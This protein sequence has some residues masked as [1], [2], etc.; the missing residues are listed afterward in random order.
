MQHSLS[1]HLCSGNEIQ[2][3][4]DTAK[5]MELEWKM[6]WKWK[7]QN[8]KRNQKKKKPKKKK[9][10]KTKKKT[11]KN[12]THTKEYQIS[13][14]KGFFFSVY[15]PT[16]WRVS[17][18]IS[19]INS[20]IGTTKNISIPHKTIDCRNSFAEMRY[21]WFLKLRWKPPFWKI[22]TYKRIPDNTKALKDRKLRFLKYP[23]NT[24]NTGSPFMT[25]HR[26]RWIFGIWYNGR[27]YIVY[28]MKNYTVWYMVMVGILL[29]RRY[30]ITRIVKSG[31]KFRLDPDYKP[32]PLPLPLLL[33]LTSLLFFL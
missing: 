20:Y 33:T 27:W 6:E 29:I 28:G 2:G 25:S 4:F 15:N 18:I 5:K 16:I 32:A 23:L 10:T 1:W 21:R 14:L 26:F 8:V 11:K 13:H 9:K 3:N 24:W 7:L 22:N 17:P 19:K 12:P 31:E 30:P